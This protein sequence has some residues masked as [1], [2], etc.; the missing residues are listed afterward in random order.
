MLSRDM[1]NMLSLGNNIQ[2]SNWNSNLSLV[3]NLEFQFQ[4]GYIWESVRSGLL[5]LPHVVLRTFNISGSDC[6]L[7]IFNNHSCY[8]LH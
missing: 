7:S 3:F 8:Y 4:L 1:L 6:L 2:Y 5:I